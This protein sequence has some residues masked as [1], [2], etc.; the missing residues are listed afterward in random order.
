MTA[1]LLLIVVTL[2]VA[3]ALFPMPKARL[4]PVR[5]DRRRKQR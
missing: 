3:Y 2:G 4:I 5:V 1:E